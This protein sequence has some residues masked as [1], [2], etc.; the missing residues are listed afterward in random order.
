[1]FIPVCI[2]LT[3]FTCYDSGGNENC[4]GFGFTVDDDS[5]SRFYDGYESLEEAA[6]AISP[7]NL[8]STVGEYFPYVLD[9]IEEE[10]GLMLGG[11]W[12]GIEDLQA[13]PE[14]ENNDVATSESPIE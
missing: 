6:D 12:V 5:G 3:K 8:L 7:K 2:I 4:T 10:G 14:N 1:M 13:G 11:L 9:L